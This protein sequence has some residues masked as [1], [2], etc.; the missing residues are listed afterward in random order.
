M[1]LQLNNKKMGIQ[2][3]KCIKDFKRPLT[4]E[5]RRRQINI[6]N[7]T[8]HDMSL[9]NGKLKLQWDRYISMSIK[10]AQNQAL[11]TPNAER[12]WSKRNSHSTLLICK[13]VE[14]CWSSLQHKHIFILYSAIVPL[15]IFLNSLKTYIHTKTCTQTQ[16]L[17]SYL[18]KFLATKISHCRWMEG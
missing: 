11:A 17:Y 8:Q 5:H 6:K 7:D 4:K 16:Q 15:G 12:M 13:M 2:F 18:T 10:M 1:L 14:P 9:G 3:L